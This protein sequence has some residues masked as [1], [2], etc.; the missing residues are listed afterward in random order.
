M[1]TE[2][3]LITDHPF[4]PGDPNYGQERECNFYVD[5]RYPSPHKSG[6]ECCCGKPADR[7]AQR[8]PREVW[9]A[10]QADRRRADLGEKPVDFDHAAIGKGAPCPRCRYLL[11]DYGFCSHCNWTPIILGCNNCGKVVMSE[12]GQEP[13]ELWDWQ[14]LGD[15]GVLCPE[16]KEPRETEE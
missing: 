10:G 13:A 4:V 15:D 7:H 3:D 16:C 11:A 9:E 5:I 8:I 12:P 14:D 2:A 6:V 1:K